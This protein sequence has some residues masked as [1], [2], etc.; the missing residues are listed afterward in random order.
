MRMVEGY[1]DAVGCSMWCWKNRLTLGS[2]F[3]KAWWVIGA[4]SFF[5]AFRSLIMTVLSAVPSCLGANDSHQGLNPTLTAIRASL[6]LLL[7]TRCLRG[8]E[9]G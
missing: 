6:L 4:T 1:S 2:N 9:M 8:S 7:T 5:F 3:S